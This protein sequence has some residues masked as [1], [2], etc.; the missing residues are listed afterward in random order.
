MRPP[1]RILENA[2]LL[3]YAAVPASA[4][5]TGCLHLYFGETRVGSVPNLAICKPHD[6]PGLLLLHCDESWRIVGLQ[7]WNAP[8]VERIVAVES[9]KQQAERYYDGLMASWKE[10]P[11]GDA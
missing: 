11:S 9:M 5:F 2:D 6:E 10:V 8:G 4:R 7:A 1:T 3:A